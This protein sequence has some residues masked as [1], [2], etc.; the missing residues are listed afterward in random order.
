MV[1]QTLKHTSSTLN[2]TTTQKNKGTRSALK[3][4]VNDALYLQHVLKTKFGFAD[5]GIVMLRDDVMH[6]DFYATRQ[7]IFR[8][9]QWLMT[10][11][12]PGDS[13]F[14]SFSGHGSQVGFRLFVVLFVVA[15]AMCVLRVFWARKKSECCPQ[16]T[17]TTHKHQQT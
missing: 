4:T 15:A 7:N 9:I 3:G 14:L 6:P 12:Q 10:G 13:L 17:H 1:C 5:S 16:H 2:N 11:L 8:G